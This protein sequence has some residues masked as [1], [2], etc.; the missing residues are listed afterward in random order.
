MD[1]YTCFAYPINANPSHYNYLPSIQ[2]DKKTS[3][4]GIRERNKKLKG[5][6]VMKGNIKYVKLPNDDTLYDYQAYKDAGVL[7]S[8]I[9]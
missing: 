5:S 3:A 1:G 9:N 7:I 2:E 4:F 6:V 8:S